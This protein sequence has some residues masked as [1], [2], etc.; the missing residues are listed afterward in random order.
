VCH[1]I[2]WLIAACPRRCSTLSHA[3]P[4]STDTDY[5]DSNRSKKI[6]MNRASLLPEKSTTGLTRN[7]LSRDGIDCTI[8]GLAP[9]EEI[10]SHDDRS[11]QDHVLFV[12]EGRV[13]VRLGDLNFILN[14]DDALHIEH[15]KEYIITGGAS[16]WSK[17]LRVDIAPREVAAPAIF[18]FPA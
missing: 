16:G 12:V 18:T 5:R 4:C 1:I 17:L 13:I 11:A 10:S 8:I 14:K 7:V 9:T 2:H 6:P 3:W 15:G